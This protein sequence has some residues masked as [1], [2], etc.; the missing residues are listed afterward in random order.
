MYSEGVLV[1]DNKSP[2]FPKVLASLDRH[3]YF[4]HFYSIS[5]YAQNAEYHGYSATNYNILTTCY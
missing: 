1:K 4:L 2:S 3:P 5:K